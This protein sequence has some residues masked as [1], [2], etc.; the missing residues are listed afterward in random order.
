MFNVLFETLASNCIYF[1]MRIAKLVILI[2]SNNAFMIFFAILFCTAFKR[3]LSYRSNVYR[4]LYG[5]VFKFRKDKGAVPMIF[6]ISR[7]TAYCFF[8][9]KI[10][11]YRIHVEGN[12]D[13]SQ[14]C[15]KNR[16]RSD[17]DDAH[18]ASLFCNSNSSRSETVRL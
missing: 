4:I 18:E 1:N 7:L 9:L 5:V 12:L 3:H 15:S 10:G 2:I 14:M 6:S 13:A 16:N 17:A 11:N 8:R